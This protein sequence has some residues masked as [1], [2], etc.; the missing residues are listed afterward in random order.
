MRSLLDTSIL[1]AL[2]DASHIHHRLTAKWLQATGGAGW[3]SC[4]ITLNGCIR[5]LSQPSYPNRQPMQKIVEGLHSAMQNPLH[6]FWPD[7]VNT[8]ATKSINWS[9][10]V[11]PAQLTDVYLLALAVAQKARFVTLDQGIAAACVPQARADQLV[12][13]GG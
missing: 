8:A 5:V 10:T 13:L 6:E 11:R 7:S 9:Y 12:V 3:A 2:L 4:P 1:I